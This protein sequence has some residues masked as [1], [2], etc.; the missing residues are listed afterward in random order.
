MSNEKQ[1]RSLESVVST[2]KTEKDEWI[3]E[4]RAITYGVKSKYLGFYEIINQGSVNINRDIT[5]TYN[6]NVDKLLGRQSSGTLQLFDKEDGLYYRLFLNKEDPEHQ[7]TYAKAKRGDLCANSFEFFEDENQTTIGYDESGIQVRTINYLELLAVNIVVN[8]AYGESFAKARSEESA[9]EELEQKEPTKE[10]KKEQRT[11]MK[12][13]EMKQKRA[14]IITKMDALNELA[15]KENRELT[16]DEVKERNELLT[17]STDL[18]NKIDNQIAVNKEKARSFDDT[19]IDEQPK[20]NR[21]EKMT[22]W[23]LPNSKE[24]NTRS[25]PVSMFKQ[26]RA[27]SITANPEVTQGSVSMASALYPAQL[28]NKLGVQI[29]YEPREVNKVVPNKIA[30]VA[31]FKGELD[32]STD[33]SITFRKVTLRA[34]KI[35][36]DIPISKRFVREDIIGATA[37]VLTEAKVYLENSIETALFSEDARVDDNPGGLFKLG[38][39]VDHAAAGVDYSTFL[40]WRGTLASKNVNLGTSKFVTSYLLDNTMRGVKLDNGSG[41]FLLEGDTVTNV[42]TTVLASPFISDDKA[43]YG[44]FSHVLVNFFEDTTVEYDPYT[45]MSNSQVRYHFEVEM[46][47]NILHKEAVLAITNILP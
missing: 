20:N 1:V 29:S 47:W 37:Q 8:P 44:D 24:T 9:K 6:H 13:D 35:S 7:S 5:M 14:E 39:A 17:E 12:I 28:L 15:E 43:L 10:A 19:N 38:T 32:A 2:P 34:K 4:G 26:D 40:G 25:I 22:N 31:G 21:N 46:D 16:E 45:L 23:T 30:G 11:Y 27:Q 3:L 36:F 41:R 33:K 18:G 42:G